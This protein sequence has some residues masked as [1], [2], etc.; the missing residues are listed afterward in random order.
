MHPKTPLSLFLK[1]Y[2]DFPSIVNCNT[3]QKTLL[4]AKIKWK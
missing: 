4:F 3:G 1:T 2:D